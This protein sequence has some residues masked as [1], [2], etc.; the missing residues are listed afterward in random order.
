MDAASQGGKIRVADYIAGF[1]AGKGISKV[2]MIVGGLSMHL[3]DAFAHEKRMG[4]VAMHHE[5]ACVMAAE[6]Y[7]RETRTVGVA[8][9]TGGPG[10]VNTVTGVV[11]AHFD[12]SPV[13]VFSGQTKVEVIRAE[14]V[15]QFGVQGF[16]TLPDDNKIRCPHR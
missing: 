6:G 5:Q 10:A 9:V 12:S 8:C 3:A 16:E 2:F 13:M 4:Y 14:G 11:S 15:R 7:A 1:I